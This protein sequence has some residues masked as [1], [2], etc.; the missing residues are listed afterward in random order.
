M[1]T[2]VRKPLRIV[3]LSSS[4]GRSRTTTFIFG[5]VQK[6]GPKDLQS[7]AASRQGHI[8]PL[9][10]QLTGVPFVRPGPS[11]YSSQPSL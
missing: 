5:D 11:S 1:S 8:S 9:R 6:A 7:L 2:T 3:A 4:Y 10:R